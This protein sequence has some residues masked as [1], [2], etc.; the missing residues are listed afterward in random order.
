MQVVSTN[1]RAGLLLGLLLGLT[2]AGCFEPEVDQIED[3]VERAAW[4]CRYVIERAI[5]TP[6]QLDA[7]GV[8]RRR[9]ATFPDPVLERTG[10]L[11]HL[12]WAPGN[13]TENDGTGIHG[14]DCTMDITGGQQLLVSATLDGAPLHAGFRF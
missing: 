13:I 7:D 4:H 6:E 10:D 14:G 12:S 11:V 5:A 3:P 9:V 1:H 2:L 8:L